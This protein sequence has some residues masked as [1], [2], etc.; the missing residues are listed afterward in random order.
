MIIFFFFSSRRRHTRYWRD[1]SSDVCSSD[2]EAFFDRPHDEIL[3]TVAPSLRVGE[4]VSH[5]FL[6]AHFD[7]DGAATAVDR[8]LR[9]DTEIMLVDDPVKRLDNMSMAWGL[10]ARVPFLDHELVELAARC[11]PR[12]KLAEDGKGVLKRAARTVLPRDVVDRPKGY[13][14]VPALRHLQ[15]GVLDFVR[16]TKIGRAHV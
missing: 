16:D 2:L 10:E 4:D 3:R 11:P 5:A 7:R 15:G 1:W 13:F 8:A 14:P 9:I 12:L 6:D